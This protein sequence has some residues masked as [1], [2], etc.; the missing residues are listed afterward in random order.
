MNWKEI[1]ITALAVVGAVVV[2]KWAMSKAA[3]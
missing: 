1:S 2:V 3:S